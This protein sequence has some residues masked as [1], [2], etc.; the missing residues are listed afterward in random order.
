MGSEATEIAAEMVR[1][2]AA[3]TIGRAGAC[4]SCA[5]NSV[6]RFW[7]AVDLRGFREITP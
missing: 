7:R 4:C 5:W 2:G 6:V 3:E 1:I